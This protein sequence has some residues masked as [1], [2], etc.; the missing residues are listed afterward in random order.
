[1]FLALSQEEILRLRRAAAVTAADS[2]TPILSSGNVAPTPVPLMYL[3]SAV[4]IALIGII[5][6]KFML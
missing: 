5:L 6:G 2:S 4:L 3:V 1:M